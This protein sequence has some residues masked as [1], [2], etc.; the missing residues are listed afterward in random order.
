MQQYV[1]SKKG[2]KKQ[3]QPLRVTMKLAKKVAQA[4]IAWC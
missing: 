2:K 3:A 4:L 1:N